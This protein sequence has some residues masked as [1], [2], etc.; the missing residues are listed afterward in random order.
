MGFLTARASYELGQI[1]ERRREYV[2]AAVWYA[3]AR[4]LWDRGGE[5]VADW[6][7]RATEGVTRVTRRAG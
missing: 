4:A 7:A 5:E 6:R 2:D 1:A 3:R